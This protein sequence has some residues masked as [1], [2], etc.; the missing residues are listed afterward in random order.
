MYLTRS[1]VPTFRARGDVPVFRQTGIM[2]FRTPFLHRFSALPATPLERA[3]SID[4]MRVLEHGMRIKGV[5]ANYATIGVDRAADVPI[6][7]KHI[8]ED[9]QQ[10]EL[11]D[12]TLA[13]GVWGVRGART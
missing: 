12:R 7:E 5:V 9:A 13:L 1:A 6:A 3:E 4:M 8:K 11:Y 10:R 2:A